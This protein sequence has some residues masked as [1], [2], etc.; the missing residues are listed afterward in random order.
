MTSSK[1]FLISPNGYLVHRVFGIPNVSD[2]RFD[3]AGLILLKA[4]EL[5]RARFFP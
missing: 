4:L 2:R 1:A 5:R 3:G